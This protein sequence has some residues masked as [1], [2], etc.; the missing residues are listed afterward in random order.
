MSYRHASR[1]A[2]QSFPESPE[3]D[4]HRLRLEDACRR[5]ASY[6][7]RIGEAFAF[8]AEL[9]MKREQLA[10]LEADLAASSRE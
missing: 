3:C 1:P 8:E 2:V 6:Q 10:D 4:N 9:E 5:L 7:S